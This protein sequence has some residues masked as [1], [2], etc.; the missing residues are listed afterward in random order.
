MTKNYDVIV[1]GGGHAGAEAAH[2]AAKMKAYLKRTAKNKLVA[3]ILETISILT[4]FIDGDATA[5]V[6]IS[7]IAVP[8]F[9][10]KKEYI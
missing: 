6:F 9:L 5:F 8:L 10:A 4:L 2:I 1:V 7:L 3:V